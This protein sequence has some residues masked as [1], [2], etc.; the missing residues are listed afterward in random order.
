MQKMPITALIERFGLLKLLPEAQLAEFKNSLG[1]SEFSVD[2]F[3]SL[4]INQ[5]LVSIEQLSSTSQEEKAD[6][7]VIPYESD[8]LEAL[9]THQIQTSID[10]P[11]SEE[12]IVPE[13]IDRPTYTSKRIVKPEPLTKKQLYTWFGIGGLMWILGI[14]IISL[15]I[16]GCMGGK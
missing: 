12:V 4:L 5:N 7:H 3:K 1:D 10:G 9:S 14:V 16:G 6:E 8:G 15:W 2:E 11:K 13:A